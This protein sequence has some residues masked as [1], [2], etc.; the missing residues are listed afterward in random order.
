MILLS[1][2]E[3]TEAIQQFYTDWC[4]EDE[5]VACYYLCVDENEL[6]DLMSGSVKVPDL[7]IRLITLLKEKEQGTQTENNL[8]DVNRL[9]DVFYH[10]QI[11]FAEYIGLKN[12]ANE[13]LNNMRKE[14][15]MRK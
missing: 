2:I 6:T 4:K 12:L 11:E 3:K 13:K 10:M 14:F 15:D 1:E 7:M 8:G 9:R 5:E